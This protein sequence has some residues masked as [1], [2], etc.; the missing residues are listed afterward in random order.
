MDTIFVPV[1]KPI[2]SIRFKAEDPA[3]CGPAEESGFLSR[4]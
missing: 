2:V 3:L 1:V 4:R